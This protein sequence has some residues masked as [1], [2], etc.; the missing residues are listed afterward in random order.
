MFFFSLVERK[1]RLFTNKQEYEAEKQI[2]TIFH[3]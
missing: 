2:L 3:I 1:V